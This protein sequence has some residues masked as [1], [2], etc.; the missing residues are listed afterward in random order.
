MPSAIRILALAGALALVGCHK[1]ADQQAQQPVAMNND[2]AANADIEA[3]P[4][5]ES[6]ATPTDQLETGD[7]NADVNDLGNAN[8][9]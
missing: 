2:I 8:S 1:K 5:D 6:S 9:E 3:L 7:D 4:A